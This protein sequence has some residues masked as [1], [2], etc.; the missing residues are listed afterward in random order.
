MVDIRLRSRISD[1]ELEQKVGKI[2]TDADYNAVLTGDCRV[3]KPDGKLLCVFKKRALPKELADEAL[4]IILKMPLGTNNRGAASGMKR[5]VPPSGGRTSTPQAMPSALLGALDPMGPQRYCR[6]TAWTGRE[7]EQ[8]Q[9]LWPIFQAVAERFKELVPDRYANQVAY[10]EQTHPD[11]LIPGTPFT[12]ITV[13]DTWPTGVHTDSGDLDEGFSCLAT[14]RRGEYT[15]GRLVFP[16]Y[17]LAVEMEDCDLILMDAHEFHG[18]SA[19]QKLEPDAHRI[20]LVHYYR[21]H[22]RECAS[23]N[24][25]QD[26][27]VAV[28]EE[29]VGV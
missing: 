17:R 9:E 12:T 29:R 7:T 5:I 22:I 19:I 20:S 26:K 2:V 4:P 11:W 15:G 10:A 18:N 28:N 27:R 6:L 24:D 8:F 3:R 25:E 21:T 23:F 13:N 14:I 16:R 1:E